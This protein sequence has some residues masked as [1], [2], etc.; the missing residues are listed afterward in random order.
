M[1]A[2]KPY[3]ES[4]RG[5]QRETIPPVTVADMAALDNAI[6]VFIEANSR[7]SH[8]SKGDSKR[9]R[10]W[11]RY[12]EGLGYDP[13]AAPL[14]AFEDLWLARKEDGQPFSPAYVRQIA[15][16]VTNECAKAG[17]TPP[18]QTPENRGKWS[19]LVRSAGKAYSVRKENGEAG[20]DHVPL[21]REAA[22]ALLSTVPTSTPYSRAARAGALMLLD[23]D[24]TAIDITH[25]LTA[26]V[27]FTEKGSVTV[28]G[29]EFTCDHRERVRGVPWDCTACAIR[30]AAADAVAGRLLAA[31]PKRW[32]MHLRA[33]GVLAALN[34]LLPVSTGK[35]LTRKSKPS[36]V[37]RTR[38][39]LTPWAL[40]GLRRAVALSE[41]DNGL[42][43]VRARAWVG[44]TWTCGFRMGSDLENLRR[45]AVRP[46]PD[47]RGWSIRLGASKGDQGG[48]QVVVR[49]FS[50]PDDV[51]DLSITS[52]LL[53]YV[54]VRDAFLGR[55]EALFPPM[56]SHGFTD[57]DTG[58]GFENAA[59]AATSD[60]RLL[61][62]LAGVEPVYTSYSLR[63]GYATQAALDGWEIEE[64]KAGM[65]HRQM[66]TTH[67][68]AA[69]RNGQAVSAKFIGKLGEVT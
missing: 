56:T 61:A 7:S 33:S 50:W 58:E 68:Y 39:D 45:D 12:C 8:T 40:A 3:A 25:A 19:A 47:D 28:A 17:L 9:W 34:G 18:H 4:L 1:P 59:K 15:R 29:I 55:D 62:E 44:I 32:T 69:A 23:S 37:L 14:S 51:D 49:P 20:V 43:W 13:L 22:V 10:W 21:L 2:P 5:T 30:E 26:D 54:C 36:S 41:L 53:E 16:A 52:M 48:S 60:V 42:R 35:P 46:D 66:S 63:H 57:S 65:R 38:D 27:T 11:K 67:G 31:G 24:L 6:D 64:I